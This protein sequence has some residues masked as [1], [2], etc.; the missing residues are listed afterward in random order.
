MS[1]PTAAQIAAANL[2]AETPALVNGRPI[3]S[4]DSVNKKFPP[5]TTIYVSP[6][7]PAPPTQYTASFYTEPGTLV[8]STT[9]DAGTE[10]PAPVAPTSAGYTFDGWFT[11]LTGG[12]LVTFPY[13]LEANVDFYAQWTAVVTPPSPGTYAWGI[14]P[15]DPDPGYTRALFDPF[16]GTVLSSAWSGKYNGQSAAGG[17]KG[18]FLAS[19]CIV[20]DGKLQLLAYSDPNWATSYESTAAIAAAVK[21]VCGGGTQSAKAFKLPFT[22]YW[23]S[24]WTTWYGLTP[25]VLWIGVWPPEMDLEEASVGANGDPVTG[26]ASSYIYAPGQ[27]IQIH[28]SDGSV[29]MSKPHLWKA[30]ATLA[31][32]DIYL[33]GGTEP[34]GSVEFTEEMITGPNGLQNE[35]WLCLQQQTG[36]GNNPSAPIA[37]ADAVVQAFGFVAVDVPT[38]AL[39]SVR[40]CA[41]DEPVMVRGHRQDVYTA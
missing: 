11:E 34:I 32:C 40:D 2:V 4:W 36:D 29:D 5:I 24:Q 16:T 12:T 37:E 8:D 23:S 21:D 25:I 28:V 39:H 38:E 27:Q 7:P 19:H 13:T 17:G 9:D 26:Y 41:E 35:M 6:A 22:T 31:G 20:A 10:I 3:R 14:N 30:E 18:I 33:D 15:P 1:T